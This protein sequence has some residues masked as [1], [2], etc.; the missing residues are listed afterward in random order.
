MSHVQDHPN[1]GLSFMSDWSSMDSREQLFKA[2]GARTPTAAAPNILLT[3][4]LLPREAGH[5]LG[6]GE[7]ELRA[8][9]GSPKS[10]LKRG[11]L[12]TH[13]ESTLRLRQ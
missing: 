3:I 7:R 8:S 10:V 4:L 9:Q 12:E 1:V 11:G 5:E 6:L 13:V 2:T